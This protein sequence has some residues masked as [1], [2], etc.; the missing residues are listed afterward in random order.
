MRNLIRN[1]RKM[2]YATFNDKTKQVDSNGDYTGDEIAEYVTPVEFHANLSAT[3]GTQGFTGTGASVDYFGADVDYSLIISTAQMDLP[4]DEHTLIWTE[5]PFPPTPTPTPSSDP[6]PTPDDPDDS[7]DGDTDEES[8][9][10]TEPNSD[11]NV[12]DDMEPEDDVDPTEEDPTEPSTPQ[13]PVTPND[14]TL[15]D[16]NT[17]QYV[18]T[19]VARGLYHMK[20]AIKRMAG[21]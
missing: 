8:N 1:N 16:P 19:A 5:N 12:V 13:E 2:W 14:P 6:M 9:D 3:R 10:D 11:T 4:I 17:A 7:Q 18:V 20:Y 21:R 15:V